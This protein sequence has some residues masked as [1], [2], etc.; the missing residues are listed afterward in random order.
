MNRGPLPVRGALMG[1][2]LLA[3]LFAFCTPSG[4][5]LGCE[6]GLAEGNLSSYLVT[7]LGKG[8]L[9][10]I[11]SASSWPSATIWV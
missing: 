4:A 8:R 10:R 11:W 2:A 5:V 3:S 1:V 6:G 7:T 9:P